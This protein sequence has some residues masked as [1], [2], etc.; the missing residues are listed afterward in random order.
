MRNSAGVPLAVDERVSRWGG[1]LFA[2]LEK[3]GVV[4][5]LRHD[6][7]GRDYLRFSP[8]FYNTESELDRVAEALR[9]TLE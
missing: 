5:S 6:R 3:A 8:H 4:A 2:A 9:S 1:A 7:E